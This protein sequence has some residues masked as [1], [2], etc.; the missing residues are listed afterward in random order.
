MARFHKLEFEIHYRIQFNNIFIGHH[1][2]KDRLITKIGEKPE[3]VKDTHEEAIVND[4]YA[5]GLYRRDRLVGHI[6]IEVS[7]L[8][9]HL[10]NESIE[11]FIEGM[12]IGK[13]MQ[14]VGL[15][16]PLKYAVVNTDKMTAMIILSKLTKKKK[17]TNISM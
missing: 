14:E 6:P 16:V 11:N 3:A 7:S 2:F 5:A 13:I 8:M 15:A 12:T 1:L 4:K 17:S 10:L 9:Y